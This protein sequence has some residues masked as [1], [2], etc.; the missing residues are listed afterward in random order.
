MKQLSYKQLTGWLL[1]N[2]T[3]AEQPTIN[4]KSQKRP[5]DTG[6]HPGISLETRNGMNG[7]Y[8]VVVYNKEAQTFILD[9]IDAIIALE[10]K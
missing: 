9:N 10:N 2:N 4:G 1:S 7:E 3:L 6:R 5:T 8:Q